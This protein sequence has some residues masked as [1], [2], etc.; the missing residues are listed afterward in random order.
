[1]SKLN[2]VKKGSHLHT[3]FASM[4]QRC[5][6]TKGFNYKYYG[7]RGITICNKWLEDKNIFFQWSFDNGYIDGLSIDR[8]DNN[9]GY[10]PENCRWV[11][12]EVQKQNRRVRYNSLSGYTGVSFSKQ[13]NKYRVSINVNKKRIHLGLFECKHDAA[14]IYNKFIIDNNLFHRL[15]DIRR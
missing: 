2:L 4:Q 7:E 13:H 5:Y 9:L 8:I 14:E 3:T 12:T 1:M 10:S 11:S 6:Y 15:N